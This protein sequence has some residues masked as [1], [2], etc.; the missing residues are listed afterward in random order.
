MRNKTKLFFLILFQGNLTPA[1]W[2][3]QTQANGLTSALTFQRLGED[4]IQCHPGTVTNDSVFLS[5]KATQRAMWRLTCEVAGLHDIR[6]SIT[7]WSTSA[8]C[9]LINTRQR[10]HGQ[11]S[12]HSHSSP[13]SLVCL[14]ADVEGR[15]ITD[16]AN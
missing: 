14:F 13:S 3:S 8:P 1:T 15:I 2:Q 12:G 6:P 7:S 11:S 10:N 16:C 9:A 4:D 5:I